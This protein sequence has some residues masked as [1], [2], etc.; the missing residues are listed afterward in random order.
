M[1]VTNRELAQSI[2]QNLQSGISAAQ[3]AQSLAAYLIVERRTKDADAIIREIDRLQRRRGVVELEVTSVRGIS[4]EL[5]AALTTMF[6]SDNK[7]TVKVHETHDPT[8]L[9][10]VLV[11]SGEQRLDLTIRRQI[12]RLKGVRV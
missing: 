3:V 1:R 12:Q 2:V 9:G 4:K 7:Q 11:E 5:K 10:G 6:N 8:V